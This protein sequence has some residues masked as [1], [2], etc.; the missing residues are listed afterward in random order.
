MI[1]P[2]QLATYLRYAYVAHVVNAP[3]NDHKEWQEFFRRFSLVHLYDSWF[4]AN[5]LPNVRDTDW[6]GRTDFYLADLIVISSECPRDLPVA[7]LFE[8]GPVVL[9]MGNAKKPAIP[10]KEVYRDD[11]CVVFDFRNSDKYP[12]YKQHG[13]VHWRNYERGYTKHYVDAVSNYINKFTADSFSLGHQ[14]H[15]CEIGC[16]DGLWL[17]KIKDLDFGTDSDEHGVA[18]AKT[19]LSAKGTP[20]CRIVQVDAHRTLPLLCENKSWG[21]CLFD[22]FEHLWLQEAFL[23]R[24]SRMPHV[25]HAFVLNPKPNNSPHHPKEYEHHDLASLWRSY[26]WS[27]KYSEEFTQRTG[28]H[29]KFFHFEHRLPR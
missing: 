9:V 27:V 22:A 2:E 28:Y 15:L 13:V 21:V 20:D 26:G 14:Q 1:T 23:R 25:E 3:N 11:D 5:K 29:K 10:H 18:A 24:L 19:M 4:A 6:V 12:L 16:G 17:H 7:S 8:F